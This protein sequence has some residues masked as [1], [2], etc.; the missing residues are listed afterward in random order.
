MLKGEHSAIPLIFIKLPF[1]IKIFGL[2]IN[3]WPFY[4]YFTVH[5]FRIYRYKFILISFSSEKGVDKIMRQMIEIRDRGII[6]ADNP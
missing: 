6:I 5:V 1:V 3:E 2:S 4:T